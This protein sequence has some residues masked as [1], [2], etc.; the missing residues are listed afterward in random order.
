MKRRYLS[1]LELKAIEEAL[2]KYKQMHDPTDWGVAENP[3]Y[4]EGS[5]P[6]HWY[7]K[8]KLL[9]INKNFLD[10]VWMMGTDEP[11]S[12]ENLERAAY[13]V[14]ELGYPEVKTVRISFSEDWG[15]AAH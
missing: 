15:R 6:Y 5:K 10:Q 8:Q 1:H 13:L 12:L 9:V 14:A 11:L 2:A 7:A 3:Y 4:F